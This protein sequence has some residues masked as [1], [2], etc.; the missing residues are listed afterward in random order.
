MMNPIITGCLIIAVI[1]AAVWLPGLW[2]YW[3]EI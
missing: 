3:D 1:F 2:W